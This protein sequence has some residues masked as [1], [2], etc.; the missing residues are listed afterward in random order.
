MWKVLRRKWCSV[1][2]GV[3]WTPS[4]RPLPVMLVFLV[5]LVTLL[6]FGSHFAFLLQ[7]LASVCVL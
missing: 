3:V 5:M 6:S 2:Y 4:T 7:G 1:G